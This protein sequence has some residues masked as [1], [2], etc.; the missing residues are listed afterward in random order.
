MCTVLY[1]TVLYC[2]VL[3]CTVLYCS[4]V[5]TNALNVRNIINNNNNCSTVTFGS[6]ITAT[7]CLKKNQNAPRPSEHTPVR[8]DT[9]S[10]RLGGIK[11][12][13]YKTSSWPD[14]NNIG[15]TTTV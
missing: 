2:T 13:K 11:G 1:C 9:M 12:C 3:Y 6:F 4:T 10:K 5:A 7:L 8:G 15:S 14:A